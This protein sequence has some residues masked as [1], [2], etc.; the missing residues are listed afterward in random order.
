[1]KVYDVFEYLNG[2]FP[3]TDAMDFDNVGILVGDPQKSISKALVALDCSLETVSFAKENDCNL[4]I[5]HH[6][7]IFEPLKNVLA[8]SVQYE[9]IKNNIAVISMHTNLDVGVGGINDKLCEILGLEEIAPV[10][11]SDGY[12]LKGG[13]ISP[14][15]AENFAQRIKERIGGVVKYVDGGKEI[16]TVLV[17]S[18]SGGDF[19]ND[20][21][22]LNYDALL[23]ADV[24]HHQFLVADDNNISLFDGGHFNTEDIIVEV[25]AD[26]LKKNFNQTQFVTFHSEIIKFA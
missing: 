9:L 4:I 19:I 3:V 16:K 17:C 24:K 12:M 22:N 10:I 8:G 21:I 6:P 25:L 14:V 18:G 23:T 20:A 5:T 15:S 7:V 1:M 2:L 13:V 26:T 11:A